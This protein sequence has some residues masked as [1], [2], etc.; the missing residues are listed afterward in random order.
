MEAMAKELG[1]KVWGCN[2]PWVSRCGMCA[3]GA[4]SVSAWPLAHGMKLGVATPLTGSRVLLQGA[5]QP[6]IQPQIRTPW[7]RKPTP[8][9]WSHVIWSP[10][11]KVRPCCV[12]ATWA[13]HM[14]QHH[15]HPSLADPG[16]AGF[17]WPRAVLDPSWP[18]L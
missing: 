13:P 16:P 8:G 7:P 18:V 14:C 2:K 17:E 9:S 1:P 12:H 11:D 15:L 4:G 6:P 5:T 3:G 10:G